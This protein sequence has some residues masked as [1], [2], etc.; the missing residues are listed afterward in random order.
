MYKKYP[1]A[2]IHPCILIGPGEF[3]T[4]KYAETEEITHVINCAYQE[5][6]PSWFKQKYPERYCCLGAHDNL[7]TSIIKWYPEFKKNMKSFL[8]E[9]DS[10]TIF[11]HCQCGIN[12]SA[13][14]ALMF[15]CESFHFSF[16]K[17]MKDILSQRPCALTNKSFKTQV[18]DALSKKST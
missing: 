8:Q 16:E 17:T 9:K 18:K 4:E 2:R 3:L 13:F 7:E 5:D 11:I 10:K 15:V 6:S 14:L 12:R 1:S